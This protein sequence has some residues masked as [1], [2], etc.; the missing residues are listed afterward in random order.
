MS[1]EATDMM[2]YDLIQ[3]AGAIADLY[4]QDPASLEP[5]KEDLT[6]ALVEV[7]H[8]FGEVQ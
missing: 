3:I 6:E 2:A 5:W 7:L 4:E 8:A 1:Q